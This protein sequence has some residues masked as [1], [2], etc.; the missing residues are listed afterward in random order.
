MAE[1]PN[2]ALG[3]AFF[4]SG[5][6]I[7]GMWP[8]WGLTDVAPDAFKDAIEFGKLPD[9]LIALIPDDAKDG[10]DIDW[11]QVDWSEFAGDA[12]WKG[13]NGYI[14]AGEHPVLTA[15][16]SKS[17]SCSWGHYHTRVFYAETADAAIR[18][19]IDW[20]GQLFADATAAFPADAA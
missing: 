5:A 17:A 8:I 2:A 10:D 1:V 20:A 15:T 11:D 13:L 9:E 16:S 18:Q 12:S 6:R 14:V 3:S 4:D 19:V 7:A